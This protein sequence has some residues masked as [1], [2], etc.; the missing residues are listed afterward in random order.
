MRYITADGTQLY[1]KFCGM[2][3]DGTKV[4]RMRRR[5]Q[6]NSLKMIV[7]S[8]YNLRICVK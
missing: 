6:T 7:R 4:R 8:V 1:K 2:D 3:L 5:K